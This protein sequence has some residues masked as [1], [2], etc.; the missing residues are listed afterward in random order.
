M[1]AKNPPFPKKIAAMTSHGRRCVRKRNCARNPALGRAGMAGTKRRTERKTT[2]PVTAVIPKTSRQETAQER[3]LPS[4]TPTRLAIVIPST[5]SVTSREALP[6]CA[7]SL[8]MIEPT[9]K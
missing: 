3:K 9:P 5:M 4:G 7:S 2:T 1:Y 8:A 6:G